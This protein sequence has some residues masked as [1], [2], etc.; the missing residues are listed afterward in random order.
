MPARHC[1]L[2]RSGRAESFGESQVAKH[3]TNECSLCG[4]RASRS[5]HSG[6]EMSGILDRMR[7]KML[8]YSMHKLV[9]DQAPYISRFGTRVLAE[10][11]RG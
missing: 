11:K 7:D 2:F 5:I 10:A 8:L 4:V 9:L 3:V 1:W 6:W